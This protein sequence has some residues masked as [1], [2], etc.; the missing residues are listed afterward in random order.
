MDG[1]LAPDH[2]PSSIRQHQARQD[3]EKSGLAGAVGSEQPEDLSDPNME[4]HAPQGPHPFGP[5]ERPGQELF[6]G[7]LLGEALL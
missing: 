4:V 1:V 5:A 6:D 7:F 3:L 2:C